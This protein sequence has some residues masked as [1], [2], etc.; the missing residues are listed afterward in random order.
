VVVF[1]IEA[2]MLLTSLIILRRVDVGAFR[3]QVSETS[4]VERAAIASDL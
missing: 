3:E 2:A 1:G 4:L